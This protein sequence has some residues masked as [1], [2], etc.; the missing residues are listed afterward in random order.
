MS[1]VLLPVLV[2]NLK[3]VITEHLTTANLQLLE[4]ARN[5]YGFRN[6]W[7]S[8]CKIYALVNGRKQIIESAF[9]VSQR[10]N[11]Y[12][13]TP[14]Y[15]TAVADQQKHANSHIAP[16]IDITH[17]P[18]SSDEIL[19][20]NPPK[21]TDKDCSSD[22]L[23]TTDFPH[24][25]VSIANGTTNTTNPKLQHQPVCSTFHSHPIQK[26]PISKVQTR[27]QT[28]F[29]HQQHVDMHPSHQGSYAGKPT[30]NY[31]RNIDMNGFMNWRNEGTGANNYDNDA[32]NN[33]R[34]RRPGRS[35]RG[36]GRQY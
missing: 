16:N 22:L 35:R 20:Q 21:K 3:L 15:S 28:S 34:G 23:S 13:T 36:R 27:A 5:M 9:K 30:D 1:I 25:N 8:Q 18:I 29:I 7:T 14:H 10:Q 24:L 6:V 26:M 12:D 2:I 31:G 11:Q 4:E 32:R 33:D 19:T 17:V